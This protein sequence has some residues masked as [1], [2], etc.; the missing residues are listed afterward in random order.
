MEDRNIKNGFEL[1][2]LLSAFGRRKWWFLVTFIIIAAAGILISL[3]RPPQYSVESII[4]ISDNYIYYNDFIYQIFP[5]EAEKLWIFPKGIEKDWEDKRI[6]QMQQELKSNTFLD[7]LDQKV[8]YISRQDLGSSIEISRSKDDRT[9]TINT[10]FSDRDTAA[11]LNQDIVGLYGED[12]SLELDA[13]RLELV[14]KI[15]DKLAD[16]ETE[17]NDLSVQLQDNPD[18]FLSQERDS[19]Y[20]IYSNL[21]QVQAALVKYRDSFINR[22]E[23][24]KPPESSEARSSTDTRR[25]IAVIFAALV[26]GVIIA[27]IAEWAVST[28][29]R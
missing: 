6:L 16:L 20:W 17:I 8:D 25:D 29:R 18:Y 2:E 15:D 22:I 24:L 1:R 9:I 3:A 13:V 7:E 14:E 23:V 27:F 19:K 12:I 11:M 4:R 5:G 10:F 21:E 28:R 26:I